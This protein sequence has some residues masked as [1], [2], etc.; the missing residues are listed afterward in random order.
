MA[1]TSFDGASGVMVA[2]SDG[3]VLA[4]GAF[5]TESTMVEVRLLWGER[6]V[7][8]AHLAGAVGFA[9][10]E[11]GASGR[12]DLALPKE[13]LGSDRLVLVER[14]EGAARVRVPAGAL[15]FVEGRDGVRRSFDARG[16]RR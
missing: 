3:G 12:V 15:G 8:V 6:L 16:A 14:E 10:G 1:M 2:A 13:K 4:E 11:G 7:H 5:E 9:V